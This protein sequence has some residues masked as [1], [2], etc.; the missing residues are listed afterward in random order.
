MGRRTELGVVVF[1]EGI[2]KLFVVVVS[3]PEVD[4]NVSHS[5]L[6][7]EVIKNKATRVDKSQ[8]SPSN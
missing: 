4:V 5:F 2:T 6:F 3:L 1:F 7:L 8:A